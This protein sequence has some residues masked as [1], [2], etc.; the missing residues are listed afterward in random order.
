MNVLLFV[1][2]ILS[3][4]TQHL[5]AED[6]KLVWS[7]EFDYDGLPDKTKWGYEEGFVRNKEKQYYTKARKQNARVENGMLIIEGKKEKFKNINYKKDSKKWQENIKYA[8]YTSVSL[9]TLNKVS[10]KYGRIE[11][12]AKLP[13]GK[14]VW[15]AIWMMGAIR[16]TGVRWPQ[17]G[18]IDIMEYVGKDPNRIHGN[19][20]YPVNGKHKSS[21]GKLKILKPYSDFHIYAVEWH[22]NRIDY[23][24]DKQKYFTFQ[25]DKAGKG[26]N[27]PFRKPFYMLINLALGGN[28]GGPIDDN[29]FPQ[30]FLVDY[31]RV[32]ELKKSKLEEPSD[33]K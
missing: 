25:I 16:S 4:L 17:C 19:A 7:D 9:I 12:K 29:I 28:W 18:E 27:N 22:D 13:K 6:K 8:N 5:Y 31:V 24:V 21:G 33:K 30:K 32:Y 1:V 26:K 11:V 14:G 3:I 10:W 20:H 2:I 15:P 23:F